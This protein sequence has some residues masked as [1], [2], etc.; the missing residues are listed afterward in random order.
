M[1]IKA[2]LKATT[3]QL[4]ATDREYKKLKDLGIESMNQ[5]ENL[6]KR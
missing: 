3:S 6:C 2:E 5:Y 4:N 1:V